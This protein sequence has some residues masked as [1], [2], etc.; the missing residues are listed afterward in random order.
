[1]QPA[2]AQRLGARFRQ[3]EISSEYA[4]GA[5]EDFA[6]F[7][8]LDIDPGQRTADRV[9]AHFVRAVHRI[10]S[11][12]FGLTIELAQFDAKRA[13]EDE[14]LLAH[15]L[16]AGESPTQPRQSELV[17]DR[18]LNEALADRIED[19]LAQGRLTTLKLAL[20]GRD[21]SR[22]EIIIGLALEPRGILG[23]HLD[24]GEQQVP[25]ARGGQITSRR[26]LAQVLKHRL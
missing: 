7:V 6:G 4:A 19:T 22:H 10:V 23:P 3:T 9:K 11:A 16:A 13:V 14:S 15:C 5:H 25:A 1:M 21:R 18:R 26:N 2:I 17:L 12:G 24:G 20:L 8:D